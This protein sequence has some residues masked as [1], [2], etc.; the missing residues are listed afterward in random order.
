MEF[1]YIKAAESQV[2]GALVAGGTDGGNR[3]LDAAGLLDFVSDGSVSIYKSTLGT[4]TN[5]LVTPEQWGA[6]MNLTRRHKMLLTRS[7][8]IGKR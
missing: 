5:I 7:K 8:H 2:I 6:I 1:A 3:T 4:A